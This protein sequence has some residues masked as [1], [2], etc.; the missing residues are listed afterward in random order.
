MV[1]VRSR[2]WGSGGGVVG[3]VFIRVGTC[4]GRDNGGGVLSGTRPELLMGFHVVAMVTY[5]EV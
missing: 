4:W 3:R 1:W 2:W 5:T